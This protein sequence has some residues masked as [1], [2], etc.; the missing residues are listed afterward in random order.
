MK[1]ILEELGKLADNFKRKMTDIIVDKKNTQSF[2]YQYD[3]ITR[4]YL[5]KIEYILED[6]GLDC[7]GK[8]IDYFRQELMARKK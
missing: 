2:D 4:Q 6:Y 8:A 5:R 3:D 1:E 7:K